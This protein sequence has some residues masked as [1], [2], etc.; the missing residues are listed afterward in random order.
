MVHVLGAFQFLVLAGIA[1]WATVRSRQGLATGLCW[2]AAGARLT[3]ILLSLL[4]SE[5]I[6][7]TGSGMETTIATTHLA[8]SGLNFL[9]W[10]LLLAAIIVTARQ[11]LTR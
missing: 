10:G 11:G 6:G 4:W 8:L 5:V 3:A 7:R 1:I 9:S 2:A